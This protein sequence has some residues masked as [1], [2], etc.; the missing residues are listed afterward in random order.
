MVTVL[1]V[2]CGVHFSAQYYYLLGLA[3][4]NLY[5]HTGFSYFAAFYSII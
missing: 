1:K 4:V 3:W 2:N 5:D